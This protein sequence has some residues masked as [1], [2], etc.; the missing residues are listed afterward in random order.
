MATRRD[1]D[2]VLARAL[3]AIRA[4]ARRSRP[5][6]R[7]RSVEPGRHG[8]RRLTA[9]ALVV[10]SVRRSL[11]TNQ[12]VA[13]MSDRVIADEFD[14]RGLEECRQEHE[15]GAGDGDTV[16]VVDP[17][18]ATGIEAMVAIQSWDAVAGGLAE[19]LDLTVAES[20]A[21]AE[22]LDGLRETTA[23]TSSEVFDD[24]AE[25]DASASAMAAA[26]EV[27]EYVDDPSA[28][29]AAQAELGPAAESGSTLSA[30]APRVLDQP[31]SNEL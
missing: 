3:R 31:Q 8:L 4:A 13:G 16:E 26:V 19:T 23:L 27:G 10:E 22:E 25:T 7:P 9:G 24:L 29:L 20:G 30:D 15:R 14:R 21:A 28:D 6:V 11:E 17:S 1:I 5:Q 2:V 12:G 18:V